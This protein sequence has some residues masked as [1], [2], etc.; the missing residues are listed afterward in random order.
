MCDVEVA[1]DCEG[2]GAQVDL[3][4]NLYKE[5]K[6]CAQGLALWTLLCTDMNS[7]IQRIAPILDTQCMVIMVCHQCH[8]LHQQYDHMILFKGRN[9]QQVYDTQFHTHLCIAEWA[10]VVV[11]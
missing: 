9:K 2:C 6:M 11:N 4:E 10:A 7:A 5:S 3:L 1:A 8:M